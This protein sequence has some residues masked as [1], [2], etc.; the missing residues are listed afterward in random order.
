MRRALLFAILAV[1]LVSHGAET[2]DTFPNYWTMGRPGHPPAGLEVSLVADRTNYFLGENIL[3]HYRIHNASTNSFKISVG[4]DYRGST[5]ADRFTVTAFS[6]DGKPVADPTPLM[7][8]FGGGL[9]PVG[10]INPGEDWFEKVWV[11]EYCRFDVAGTYTVHAF[12][13]LG[14]GEKTTRDPRETTCTIQLRAPSEAGAEAILVEAENA[15]PDSGSTWG[16]K[17]EARLDYRCI[18]WPTFLKPLQHRAQKE[19]ALEGIASIR[20][21][22]ATRALVQ[23]LEQTNTAFAAKAARALEVRLPHPD[24][25]FSGP[26]G[27]ER[28]QF[29]IEGV[30]DKSFNRPVREGLRA[31]PRAE[32]ARRFADSDFTVAAYRHHQ[33]AAGAETRAGLCRRADQRGIPGRYPLPRAHPRLRLVGRHD[34]GPG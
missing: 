19:N 27:K 23:L 28:R 4:G 17:G 34:A 10:E 3:L 2:N 14:F 8:N 1:S 20:T 21:L 9:M 16:K 31:L 33:R 15:K 32:R 24:S 22:E 5:R 7:R 13:D 12:H 29:I 18:R 11:L 6:A 26:W 25:D 30:W